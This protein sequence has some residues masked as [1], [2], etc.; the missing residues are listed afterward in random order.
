MWQHNIEKRGFE[1]TVLVVER[2]K[3]VRAFDRPATAF[4]LSINLISWVFGRVCTDTAGTWWGS[5][6][7]AEYRVQ[8][9]IAECIAIVCRSVSLIHNIIFWLLLYYGIFKYMK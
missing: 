2:L 9:L 1:P 3:A 7:E 4:G 8:N 5:R 6:L